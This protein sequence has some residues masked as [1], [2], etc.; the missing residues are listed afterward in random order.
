MTAAAPA[1]LAAGPATGEPAHGIKARGAVLRR[2]AAA[3]AATLGTTAARWLADRSARERGLLAVCAAAIALL[4]V[5]R[6]VWLPL[7]AARQ[8]ALAEVARDDR[9]TAQ[10][11]VAG[12]DVA[13]IAAA[14]TGSLASLVADR[15]ARAGL[16]IARL[17]PLG[18]RVV[19]SL[20]DVG[21]TP[22]ADWLAAL[23]AEAAVGV[24]ELK[25]ERRSAPGTVTAQVTLRER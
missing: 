9:L 16:T 23:D 4:A 2:R 14:R 1:R 17:E 7:V 3:R 6:L 19:V 10:L 20:D 12:P 13:R 15:A 8:A 5:V 18:D 24:V 25:V 21:F 11:R 22:L